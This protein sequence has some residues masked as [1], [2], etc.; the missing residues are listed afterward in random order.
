MPLVVEE[1]RPAVEDK[2]SRLKSGKTDSETD[3]HRVIKPDSTIGWQEWTDQTIRDESGKIVEFQSVGRDITERKQAEEALRESEAIYRAAIEVA[4]AVPYRQTYSEGFITNYDFIGEGIRELTGYGPEEFNGRVW[5]ALVQETNLLGDLAEYSWKEAIQ[6]VRTGMIPIWQCEQRIR[7]RNGKT[8]WVYEAAVELRD[9]DGISHGSIGLFQ[10]I[11]E[12]KRAEEALR[13]SEE[14][15]SKAFQASPIIITISRIDSGKLLE[16]NEA[17][18]KVMGFSREEVIGKTA[19]ELELWANQTDRERVMRNFLTN[20]KLKNEELQFRTKHGNIITCD[21]SAELIELG[22]EKCGIAIV[23][24]IT[25]RKKAEVRILR[26]NRLYATISQINQTIVHA[27]DK[28]SLF[29]ENCRVALDD[30]QFRMAWVGLLNENEEEIKPVIFAGE[31]LGYLGNLN[32]KYHDEV[33]GSGPTG[34]AIREGRCI[35]CQDIANDPRMA[36]WREL[37]LSRG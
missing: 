25:D 35:I 15:F 26:L 34:T 28:D 14:R 22:G 9:K 30:R 7:T 37:A 29:R 5:N 32:I 8:R 6:R 27:R 19:A 2:V 31:E 10:D 23:E 20:G 36:P 21:Y 1:D 12:R 18:E 4:G 33:L 11:T 13:I 3:I 17:F 24:D 16:V